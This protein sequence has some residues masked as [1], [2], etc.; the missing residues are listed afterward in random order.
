MNQRLFVQ[1]LEFLR[2]RSRNLV[3]SPLLILRQLSPIVTYYGD[4]YLPNSMYSDALAH[5]VVPDQAFCYSITY[6]SRWRQ[7]EASWRSHLDTAKLST[8]VSR[9]GGSGVQPVGVTPRG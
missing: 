8:L 7:G 3:R 1:G 4:T 9:T 6:L 2:E 5:A